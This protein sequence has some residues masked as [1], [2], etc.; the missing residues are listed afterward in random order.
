[1][2]TLE[3]SCK[4]ALEFCEFLWREVSLNDYCEHK[5]EQLESSL[6]AALAQQDEHLA[7]LIA[8]RDALLELVAEMDQHEGAEGWSES[9]RAKINAAYLQSLEELAWNGSEPAGRS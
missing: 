5:R 1:M 2:S 9:T 6:R 4:Q 3:K 8:Q 7:T